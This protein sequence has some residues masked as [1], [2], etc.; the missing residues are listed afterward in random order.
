MKS[1]PRKVAVAVGILIGL[2]GLT[3]AGMGSGPAAAHPQSASVRLPDG[4]RVPAGAV[5]VTFNRLSG[6]TTTPSPT[7]APTPVPAPAGAPAA[8][9][10]PRVAGTPK[11]GASVTAVAET[12]KNVPKSSTEV[13]TW[14]VDGKPVGHAKKLK[15]KSAWKGH[16]LSVQVTKTWTTKTRKHGR[17]ITEH[18]T[19]GSK[20]KAV[21]IH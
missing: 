13:V 8:H 20:S 19:V 16:K 12:F 1:S 14:Y 15:L 11:S 2:G 5:S 21:K 9:G 4:T 3:I 18:H 7:H 6:P 10:T 17:T